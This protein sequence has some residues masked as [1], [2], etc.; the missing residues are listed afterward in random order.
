[1]LF[2]SLVL[3]GTTGHG[4]RPTKA[5]PNIDERDLATAARSGACVL[6]TGPVHVRTLAL[7]IHRLS[8]GHPGRFK[9]VDCAASESVLERELFS[10]LT[11]DSVSP[12]VDGSSARLLHAGTLF[13]H[14]IGSLG[15]GAQARLR[16]LLAG[17]DDEWLRG[18][19]RRIIA[20]TSAP[21]LP[22]VA[23]GTFDDCLFYRL[24][25]FHFILGGNGQ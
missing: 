8:G 25:V 12:S 3:A 13:L 10:V 24:N 5:L 19:R 21:L 14:E 11:D 17:G 9:A 7:R 2:P 18:S 15:R 16:D 4:F 22:R 23:A 20:S 6:F 1:M